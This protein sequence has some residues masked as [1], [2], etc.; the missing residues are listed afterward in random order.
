MTLKPTMCRR[1]T[2]N[3]AAELDHSRNELVL[4]ATRDIQCAAP[5]PQGQGHRAHVHLWSDFYWLSGT[6]KMCLGA[7]NTSTPTFHF[8]HDLR[9][10]GPRK[11]ASL[12]GDHACVLVRVQAGGG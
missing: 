12:G 11:Q 1:G 2:S 6:I 8:L 10:V 5:P 9:N 7:G 4:V 3:S